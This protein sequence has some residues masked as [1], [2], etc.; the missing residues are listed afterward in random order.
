[1][2]L[3]RRFPLHPT[4]YARYAVDDAGMQLDKLSADCRGGLGTRVPLNAGRP[5]SGNDS[6]SFH[7]SLP[8]LPFRLALAPSSRRAQHGAAGTR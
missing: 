7:S 2:D 8:Q 4:W 5:C 3:R 6:G 1:M